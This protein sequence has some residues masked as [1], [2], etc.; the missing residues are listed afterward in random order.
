MLWLI[1]IAALVLAPIVLLS[2]KAK[3]GDGDGGSQVDPNLPTPE[4]GA[5]LELVRQY[6]IFVGAPKPWQDF[7]VLV[8]QRESKGNSNVGA[9]KTDGA[10]PWAKIYKESGTPKVAADAYDGLKSELGDCWPR[11][12]YVFGTGGF[13]AMFPAYGLE[14][15]RGSDLVCLHPWVVFDPLISMIMA[16]HFAQRLTKWSS[17]K[18]TVLSLRAGWGSP[19]KMGDAD[20]LASRRGKYRA[21]AVKAGLDPNFVDTMLPPWTPL[22]GPALFDALNANR[23]WLP[24]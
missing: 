17:Y 21:D 2:G 23:G 15:F 12:G 8:A 4:P 3:A 7:F 1:P 10:P 14:A 19:T 22:S 16:V 6:A 24:P 9:G 13:F 18:G 11:A 20:Y 5:G